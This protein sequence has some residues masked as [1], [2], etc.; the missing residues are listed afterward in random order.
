MGLKNVLIA[1]ADIEKSKKFYKELFGL[2]VI[3]DFGENVILSEGLVLQCKTT[4]QQVLA[5][6]IIPGN[7]FELFFE[8]YDFDEF[9][10]SVKNKGNVKLI[11]DVYEN[12]WGRRCIRLCD[13]DGY[14]IEVA[15]K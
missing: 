14:L 13:P 4:W 7:S 9:V 11:E 12:A 15:E 6:D 5:S 1:V 3:R 2:N 10:L 8:E